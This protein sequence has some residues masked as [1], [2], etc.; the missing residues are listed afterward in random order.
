M[1]R[2]GVVSYAPYGLLAQKRAE[3]TERDIRREQ[4]AKT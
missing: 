1:R 4:L 2:G 3:K